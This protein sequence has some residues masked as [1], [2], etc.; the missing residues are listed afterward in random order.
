MT[1]CNRQ[2]LLFSSLNQPKVEADLDGGRLTSEA[3]TPGLRE[4]NG[5]TGLID[6]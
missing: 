5:R 2:E 3:G 6:A 1:E 4:V